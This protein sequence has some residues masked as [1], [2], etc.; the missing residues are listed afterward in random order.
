VKELKRQQLA[1]KGLERPQV[2]RL[3]R[4]VELRQDVRANAMFRRL[5]ATPVAG[6]ADYPAGD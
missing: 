1:P 2:G 4:G 5:R 6:W 3:L